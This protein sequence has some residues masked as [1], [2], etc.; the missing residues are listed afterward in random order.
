TAAA[1]AYALNWKDEEKTVLVFD[2]GGGTFD[3]SI[4]R[5][6]GP[7]EAQSDV[8]NVAATGVALPAAELPDD[9]KSGSRLRVL[10]TGGDTH[11]GGED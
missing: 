11:L 9:S 3:V 2:F 4:L 1:M 6:E 10:S 8:E 7:P 5:T